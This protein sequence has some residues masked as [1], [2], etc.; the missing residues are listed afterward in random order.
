VVARQRIDRLVV[1]RVGN[2]LVK[3]GTVVARIAAR[4]TRPARIE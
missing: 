4:S 3:L 2:A 1:A